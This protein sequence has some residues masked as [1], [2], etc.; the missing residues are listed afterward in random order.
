MAEASSSVDKVPSPPLEYADLPADNIRHLMKRAMGGDHEAVSEDSVAVVQRCTSEFINLVASEARMRAFK[1]R[2]DK[3]AF[4]DVVGALNTLGFKQFIEPIKTHV[5]LHYGMG[6]ARPAK[7]QRADVST[8]P[9]A[10]IAARGGPPSTM[11][12]GTASAPPPQPP[13][14]PSTQSP[15]PLPAQPPV[16]S[17]ITHMSSTTEAVAVP[18]GH[19]ALSNGG[20]ADAPSSSAQL[21]T[22]SSAQPYALSPAQ[23]L[24][25]SPMQPL[26][27][28]LTQPQAP[29]VDSSGTL[30]VEM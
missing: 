5:A 18:T 23:P 3:V 29:L 22:Q 25:Q 14:Q 2:H 15:T 8:G 13:P 16:Q 9:L 10:E 21:P 11:S 12:V 26:T 7:R 24:A 20:A 6:A 19:T 4:H 27:Q 1:D 17:A 30:V 28:P